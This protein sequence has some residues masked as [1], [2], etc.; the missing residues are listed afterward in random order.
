VFVLFQLACQSDEE[1]AAALSAEITKLE[2]RVAKAT[3]ARA[4]LDEVD[5]VDT[6]FLGRVGNQPGTAEFRLT[7]NNDTEH[8]IQRI[9]FEAVLAMPDSSSPL[10]KGKIDSNTAGGLEPGESAS[11]KLFPMP[12][13]QWG[14]YDPPEG[15][16]L[17]LTPTRLVGVA[18]NVLAEARSPER[19]AKDEASLASLRADL[20]EIQPRSD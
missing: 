3:A 15:A 4:L 9:Q 6:Q 8:R 7:I 10:L 16:V 18:G 1:R 5:V 2:D 13:S 14:T 12:D 20:Q 11:L 17:D 19:L